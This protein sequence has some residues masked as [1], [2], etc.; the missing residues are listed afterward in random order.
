[1][2]SVRLT[3]LWPVEYSIP[4]HTEADATDGTSLR[5]LYSEIT[6][7]VIHMNEAGHYQLLSGESLSEGNQAEVG[8]R[9]VA[10][11]SPEAFVCI[12]RLTTGHFCCLS[13]KFLSFFW[14]HRE[15][16]DPVP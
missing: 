8:Q 16:W 1:M 10:C 12:N 2:D 14:L 13:H 15:L 11:G 5:D 4:R 9:D 6:S 7:S 3:Q